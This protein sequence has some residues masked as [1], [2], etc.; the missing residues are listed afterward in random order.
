[1]KKYGGGE[2]RSR[3]ADR[4]QLSFFVFS[5]LINVMI[6]LN[7]IWKRYCSLDTYRFISSNIKVEICFSIEVFSGTLLLFVVPPTKFQ[8]LPVPPTS[9]SG[10]KKANANFYP[11]RYDTLQ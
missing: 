10:A 5:R 4:N 2:A 7:S 6:S 8:Y 9:R 1:M 3:I 11:V